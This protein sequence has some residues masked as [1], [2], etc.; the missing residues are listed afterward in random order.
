MIVVESKIAKRYATAFL[1]VTETQPALMETL[2]AFL[3]FLKTHSIFLA[4]LNVPSISLEKKIEVI[5]KVLEK[6]KLIQVPACKK[7]ILLLLK[8]K[9][10]D[11]LEEVLKKIIALYKQWEKKHH[12]TVTT[13][14]S[15][16]EEEEVTV[17]N[18]IQ[19]Q[20]TLKGLSPKDVT[21]N[22]VVDPSLISGIR[23]A[24]NTFLWERSIAK[25]LRTLEQKILR[26]EEE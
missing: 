1:R 12:F 3:H 11:L 26:Q 18:F 17:L 13:S 2:G 25:Q 14:H 5:E 19:E 6:Q 22:F 7:L 16:E 21:A 24:G 10:I 20:L 23:I 15:L 4:T 8:D 9:R